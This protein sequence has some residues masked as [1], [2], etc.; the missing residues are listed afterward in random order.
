MSRQFQKALL[1]FFASLVLLLAGQAHT[2]AA[3]AARL[4]LVLGNA[5]YQHAPELGNPAN[6]AE[7]LAQALRNLGFEVIEQRDAN[8]EAMAKAI[9]DFSERLPGSEVALFFYAGHG[10]QMNGENYLVPV[11]AN[12][13]DAADVRFHT[14][15][16]ADIQQEMESGGRTSIIILDACRSNPFAEKLAQSGRSIGGRG[17]GRMEASAKGSLIVYSTQPNNIAFDGTGR[18]SPFTA[19]LLKHV[20]TP[21]LEVR[22]M[23][24]RVRGDVLAATDNQQ[25]PWDSSSLVGDVY[26]AGA[27]PQASIAPTSVGE[28]KASAHDTAQAAAAVSREASATPATAAAPATECDNIAAVPPQNS[29]SNPM[30]EKKEPDWSRGV[31]ACAAEVRDHPDEMRFVFQLGRAQDH[32]KNYAEAAHEYRIASDAG[33]PQAQLGLGVLYYYGHGVVQSYLTA[34]ELFSKV[35]AEGSTLTTAKAMANVGGMYADGRGVAKDDAKSLDYEEKSIEM[36]NPNALRLV[37]IHYFN[38]AGVARDYQMA[39]QYFQQA[40]DVGDGFSM[41]FL[42]NMIEGGYLGAPDPTKAGE[43]RLKAVQVDPDSLSPAP[44]QRFGTSA[45][46][47]HV[48]RRYY[49]RRYVVYRASHRYTYNPAWQAAPGD[50]RCCPNNMLVCPLGR[51]FCGH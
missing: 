27:A 29:T 7:D 24:S 25:T 33:F 22:Q 1:A 17:L 4:A 42:A 21:G 44:L 45:S 15:N 51:H 16:L 11:D 28:K 30:R 32:L 12:I 6:D 39:A 37:A 46:A 5:K 3:A 48:R 9:R 2:P 19:A 34:F 43:L 23:I 35:A 20:N 41:K 31:Q 49:R 36:G 13:Q 26:L 14:I 38:G 10:L 50:T 40:I 18:N 8:R 47:T